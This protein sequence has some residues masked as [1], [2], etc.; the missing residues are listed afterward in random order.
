MAFGRKRIEDYK[1]NDITWHKLGPCI[2]AGHPAIH[3]LEMECISA[4]RRWLY[5][6]K[7]FK[8]FLNLVKLNKG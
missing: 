7:D 2:I 4:M 8:D 1:L 3:E 5:P 6:N